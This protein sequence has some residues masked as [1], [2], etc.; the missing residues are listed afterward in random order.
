MSNK[1]YLIAD[2]FYKDFTGG[3]E[4]NDFSLLQQ[5]RERG[6]YVEEVYC[7][8]ATLA[9]L[10]ANKDASF[11]VANFVTLTP[12]SK[13]Y[14]IDNLKY[15][16]YEHDHKYLKRRNPIFYKHFVAP[17]SDRVN[18]EFFK[19]AQATI[20][21]T[22]LALNV[23][24]ENTGLDNVDKIG[25]SVWRD[26]DLDYLIELN[27]AVGKE[28]LAAIMDSDNPIKKKF[29]CVEYCTKNDIPYELIA[30]TDHRG[31]LKKLS[32]YE[33]LVFM[34]GH[35]E[36]C[37]RLVVEAK[38]LNCEVI[39]QKALIGA[40]SEDWFKLDGVELIEEI[41][42]ISRNSVDVFLRHFDE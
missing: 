21:L 19:N 8:D 40:C 32:G 1:F 24:Q 27:E 36:T 28:P 29:Q 10:E 41:R 33:K 12:D 18:V 38:M 39:T 7:K 37:C 25:A 23:F 14:L 9:F 15:I 17:V 31:F 20:C 22:Q 35:L 3:A 13:Q 30:D 16:I 5:F 6:I 26:E 4:L 11:I 34:T 2:F 42:K